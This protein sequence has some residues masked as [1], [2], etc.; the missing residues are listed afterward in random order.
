MFYSKV[1]KVVHMQVPLVLPG[2]IRIGKTADHLHVVR[3]DKTVEL[4][5]Q[6]GR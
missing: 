2:D 6:S 4:G 3:G 5:C 1:F